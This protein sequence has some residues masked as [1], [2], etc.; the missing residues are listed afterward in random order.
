MNVK[1]VSELPQNHFKPISREAVAR[2]VLAG[3]KDEGLAARIRAD[4]SFDVVLTTSAAI[5]EMNVNFY[6]FDG[7]VPLFKTYC[8]NALE[9]IIAQ[10]PYGRRGYVFSSAVET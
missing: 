7:P 5:T 1:T 4:N 3:W 6:R 10:L 8:G 9:K 2:C